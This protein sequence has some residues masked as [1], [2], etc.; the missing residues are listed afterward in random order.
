MRTQPAVK[1]ALRLFSRIVSGLAF[2]AASILPAAAFAN[3]AGINSGL[4]LPRFVSLKSSRVN[5]RVGPGPEYQVEWL[6]L[7]RGFPVEIIQEYDNW[8]KVRDV[9]GNEGW[10]LGALLSGERTAI[11]APWNE[12][13]NLVEM[14]S[15]PQATNAIVA[16]VE[17]GAV[18]SIKSC[19]ESWCRV[20]AQGVSGFVRQNQLWGVYPDEALNN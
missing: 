8:R 11:V 15:D 9:E 1:G 10:I 20:E 17:P 6:Y 4:P 14:R 13:N 7:R 2:A 19:R 12:K 16:H 18:T 3:S 5:M